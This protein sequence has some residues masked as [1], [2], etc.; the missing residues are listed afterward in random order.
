MNGRVYDPQTAM[1]YSPD[2]FIQS[3]GDWKN[4]NRYSYCMNNP[5]RYTDPSGYRYS[6]QVE[7]PVEQAEY[8]GFTNHG[9]GHGFS[10]NWGPI[11]YNWYSEKYEYASG[12]EASFEDVYNNYILPHSWLTANGDAAKAVYK[13]VRYGDPNIKRQLANIK[14]NTIDP[15]KEILMASGTLT[16]AATLFL[17]N[18]LA[19]LDSN[20]YTIVTH[21]IA[22]SPNSTLSSFTAIGSRGQSLSGYFLEPGG[23]STLTSGMDRRI[24]QGV[25]HMSWTYSNHF[26]RN[27]YLITS[28]SV[29]ASRGIRMHIGNFD[30]DTEGC[31]LPGS[32][33]GMK[34]GDYYVSGSTKTYQSLINILNT[35]NCTLTV[36]D[37]NH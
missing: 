19:K 7:A 9:G 35:N 21:R 8:I 16:S 12:A 22:E 1:F 14:V 18:A 25:Y 13:N 36:Y 30:Y 27:M 20:D 17:E 15:L 4:Y 24:P 2:P 34:N 23:P 29:P 3:A 26:E 11:S 37:I 28:L 5:T 10:A 31:F 32:S 33:Y 6:D